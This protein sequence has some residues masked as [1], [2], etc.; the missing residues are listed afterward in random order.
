MYERSTCLCPIKNHELRLSIDTT[1]K[2]KKKGELFIN[3]Q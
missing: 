1:K 3:G 2:K